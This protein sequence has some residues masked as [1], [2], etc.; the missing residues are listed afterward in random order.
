MENAS[1]N[2]WLAN[3]PRSINC[4]NSVSSSYFQY[5]VPSLVTEKTISLPSSPLGPSWPFDIKI[6]CGSPPLFVMVRLY[7]LSTCSKVIVGENPSCPGS[8][9]CPLGKNASWSP[10]ESVRIIVIPSSD[11]VID[12]IVIEE[13]LRDS[14]HYF[15]VPV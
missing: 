1:S 11:S 5:T 8:P 14:S 15:T 9:C 4:L 10:A 13:P 3:S 6:V 2:F 12:L 7:P